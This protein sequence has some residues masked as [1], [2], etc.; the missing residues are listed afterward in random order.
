MKYDSTYFQV[1]TSEIQQQ[2]QSQAAR[3]DVVQALLAMRSLDTGYRFD[4]DNHRILDKQ[5]RY[6]I[7]D[8]KPLVPHL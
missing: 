6:V 1:G 3:A 2:A 7:A 8:Y 5:V 4:F